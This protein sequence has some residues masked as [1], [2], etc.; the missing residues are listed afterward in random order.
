MPEHKIATREEWQVARVE[1]AKL[2]AEQALRDEEIK[3][4]R[5]ELPWVPVDKEY[6]FDT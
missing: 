5:G 2:E 1:L 6:V 4:K 3:R